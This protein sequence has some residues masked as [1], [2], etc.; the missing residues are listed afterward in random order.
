VCAQC[1]RFPCARFERETGERDSFVLHRRVMP[2]QHMIQAHGLPA[3]LMQQAERIA[4][5]ETALARF[6]DGRSKGYFCMA[7]TLLSADG[8]RGALARAEAGAPL[9]AELARVAD[10]EGQELK[11]RT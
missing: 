6:D 9:R 1:E 2:N 8:L 11:L 10:M 4:F 3:F 7:A 5:L